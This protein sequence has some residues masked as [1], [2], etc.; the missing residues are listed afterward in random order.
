MVEAKVIA[1][2]YIVI[3]VDKGKYFRPYK[4]KGMPRKIKFLCNSF[5]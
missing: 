5:D 4:D 1:L 3:H 2:F